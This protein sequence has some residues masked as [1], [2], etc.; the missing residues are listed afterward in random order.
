[1]KKLS[2]A[3]ILTPER[4]AVEREA[5]RRHVMEVKRVRRVHLGD[6]LTFLFE[7]TDTMRYQVQEMLRIENRGTPEAVQH[8]VDTYNELIPAPGDL[9]CTLLIEIDDEAKRDRLLREWK[10]LVAHLYLDFEDGSS[11]KAQYD[12]RQVGDDRL[13]SVQYLSF[14]CDGKVPLDVRSDLPAL[15]LSARIADEVRAA[16]AADLA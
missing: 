3:I 8:E 2:P 13:S 1:M 16:L 9:C 7:N 10:D 12:P 15:E 6:H 11:A 14:A 5:F 4:Y